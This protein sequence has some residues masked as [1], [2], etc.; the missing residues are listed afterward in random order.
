MMTRLLTLAVIAIA[1]TAVADDTVY[2]CLD[3]QGNKL[4]TSTTCDTVGHAVMPDHEVV[5]Q[6]LTRI[7]QVDRKIASIKREIMDQERE[8]RAALAAVHTREDTENIT[9]D[10]STIEQEYDA[11]IKQ[12]SRE[13]SAMK[14][15]RNVLME[16]SVTIFLN[17]P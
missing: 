16:R 1:G 6:E 5:K 9:A 10:A 2:H 11:R 4:F 15:A 8:K 13:L 12:L 7:E 3:D 14:E 17:Q